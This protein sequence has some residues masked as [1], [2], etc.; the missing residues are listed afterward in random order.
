MLNSEGF[1]LWADGYDKSVR[2]ADEGDTYPFAGYRDVL[3]AIY[4][5]VRQSGA[6]SV[7]DVGVGTGVLAGRLYQDGCAV[8]ALDFSAGMLSLAREKMPYARLIQ[9]DFNCGL[10]PGLNGARFDAIVSTY[11]LHHLKGEDKTRLID[12]LLS[13][14][15]PGGGLWIGDVA[16]PSRAALEDCRQKNIQ[17]W[18]DDEDYLVFDELL[19]RFPRAVFTPF[20]PCAGVAS[21]RPC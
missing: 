8:T 20:S 4:A 7:L 11:A 13:C 16:F 1:D 15:N 10:P 2:L 6:R 3:A 12:A 19:R 5:A 9:W 21:I 14:L 17:I 18:D